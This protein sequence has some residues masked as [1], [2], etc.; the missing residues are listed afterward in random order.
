MKKFEE[1]SEKFDDLPKEQKRAILAVIDEKTELDMKEVLSEMRSIK[2]SM[3]SEITSIKDSMQSEITSIKDSMQ[4]EITSIKD[5]M[6]SKFG[7]LLWVVG[8]VGFMITVLMTIFKFL[9]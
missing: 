3:Q 1:L 9:G 8:V 6:D 7:V 5:S 4:S 2:E